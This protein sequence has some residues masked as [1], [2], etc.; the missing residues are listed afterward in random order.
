MHAFV[1]PEVT[2]HVVRFV[3]LV[4]DVC[5]RI[6]GNRKRSQAQSQSEHIAVCAGDTSA[7]SRLACG[8]HAASPH[9]GR[10]DCSDRISMHI[11][12]A[13]HRLAS[14]SAAHASPLTQ[15]ART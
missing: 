9:H 5:H 12:H 13:Q 4:L 15:A 2:E 7:L 11:Q 10:R 8:V 3:H 6:E 14:C 1:D